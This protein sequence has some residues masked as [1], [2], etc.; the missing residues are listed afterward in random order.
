[1]RPRVLVF[2]SLFPSAARPR[3]GIMVEMRLRQLMR[4]YQLD[5]RVIA[6]VPWF[7]FSSAIFGEYAK[8]AATPRKAVRDTGLQVAYPRYLMVPR[9]GIPLQ[10]ESMARAALPELDSLQRAGWVP[11]IIDAH[12]FYPD[13]VAAALLAKRIQ[14]PLVVTARGSDINVLGRMPAAARRIVWAAQQA[15]AVIA[16]SPRLKEGLVALG[17]DE[18]KIVVLRNGV[19][20]ELFKPDDQGAA[21]ERCGLPR[22]G[23]IAACV[24]NLLPVKG[25]ALAIEALAHLP[26]WHLVLVGDGPTRGQLVSLSQRLGVDG[27]V[28]FIPTMP[29][30]D[31]RHLYSSIDVLLLPS[32][33][34][35]WPNVVLEALACGRP[36]VAT[37]AGAVGEML[38]DPRVG[39]VVRGRDPAPFAAAV[40][41]MLS[42]AGSCEE[43]RS[44]AS[45]FDWSTISRGQMDVFA[46]ALN[47]AAFAVPGATAPACG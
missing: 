9:V 20:L 39:R 31:L 43:I 13:G 18:A 37:D 25:Q 47:A 5:A 10:P 26:D 21:S 7:P 2:S 16:V 30:K 42:S 3:H 35:G 40:T 45:R 46:R 28:R 41:D 14:R 1:M 36:V 8:L 38:S 17:V 22:S 33:R 4:D 15:A 34:E 11:D 12:Y 27:R 23:R 44:H 19:D 24:G 6:P 32:E 29:Q